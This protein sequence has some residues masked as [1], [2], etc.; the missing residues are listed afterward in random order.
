ME[1]I[2][3]RSDP[4]EDGFPTIQASNSQAHVFRE[5]ISRG[6]AK[7]PAR[8]EVSDRISVFILSLH[9]PFASSALVRC[10]DLRGLRGE[11]VRPMLLTECRPI[12][13]RRSLCRSR[14]YSPPGLVVLPLAT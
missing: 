12:A 1:M 8:K 11:P 7:D 14:S 10:F 9:S 2:C 6:P 5:E 4:V 13:G 3:R